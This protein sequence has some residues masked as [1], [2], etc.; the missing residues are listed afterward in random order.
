MLPPANA[1]SLAKHSTPTSRKPSQSQLMTIRAFFAQS[2]KGI[3]REGGTS[4]SRCRELFKLLLPHNHRWNTVIIT[5]M[6][7]KDE[8]VSLTSNMELPQLQR[9]IIKDPLRHNRAISRV[10]FISCGMPRLQLLRCECAML[11]SNLTSR[12]ESLHLSYDCCTSNDNV[13]NFLLKADDRGGLTDLTLRMSC[14]DSGE[15]SSH[16]RR[17]VTD[18]KVILNNLQTFSLCF[19]CAS[20]SGNSSIYCELL[21]RCHMPNL[22]QHKVEF[23]MGPSVKGHLLAWMNWLKA[24]VSGSLERIYI[25]LDSSETDVIGED[26]DSDAATFMMH[27]TQIRRCLENFEDM[28]R[29]MHPKMDLPVI[30]AELNNF[31]GGTGRI[32]IR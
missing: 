19:S 4:E 21:D 9:L 7:S 27:V 1:R 15:N 22:T 17:N 24:H 5:D 30:R 6:E 8:F 29:G 28:L 23:Q 11:P 32:T 16:E 13:E 20:A 10:P 14:E 3:T 12:L 26:V 25:V 2:N 31:Q 18:R